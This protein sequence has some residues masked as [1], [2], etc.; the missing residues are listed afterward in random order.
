MAGFRIP[1]VS[2][3][4]VDFTSVSSG[5][6]EDLVLADRVDI[7]RWRSVTLLVAISDQSTS[8]GSISILA[9]PQSWT[10]EDPGVSFLS[11]STFGVVIDGTT[12]APAYLNSSLMMLGN[13]CM[14]AMARI[15]A[16]GTKTGAGAL[17]ASVSVELAVTDA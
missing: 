6:T 16:R 2:K 3:R 5:G 7:T 10:E 1:V 13:G 12:P 17:S 8:A 11:T 14:S 9:I 4:K 15:V